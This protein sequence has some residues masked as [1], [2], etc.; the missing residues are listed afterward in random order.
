MNTA[1]LVIDVQTDFAS[2]HGKMPIDADEAAQ[3]I[4]TLNR[5][6]PRA[7]AAGVEV[8]YIRTEWSNPILRLLNRGSARPGTPG[9]D[10]DKRLQR[11]PGMV[12]VKGRQDVFTSREF[13]DH[14]TTKNIDHLV[15]T[16]LAAEY[17]LYAAVRSARRRG[18]RVTVPRDA[19]AAD[20]PAK[21][22]AMLEKY[23]AAG[24]Q[25]CLSAD[26]TT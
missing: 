25:V 23:R 8:M 20:D 14:I 9:A 13:T 12:F 5:L 17:C 10:F 26:I 19:I 2:S 11:G 1:L 18:L 24:A 7:H 3:L 16:G 15:I 4:A 21:R 6:L 22:D